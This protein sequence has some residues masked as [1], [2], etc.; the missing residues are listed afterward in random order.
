MGF[1][2]VD[3][4][5]EAPTSPEVTIANDKVTPAEAAAQVLDYLESKGLLPASKG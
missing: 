4:P 3:D 1:T 2:G 5:Y